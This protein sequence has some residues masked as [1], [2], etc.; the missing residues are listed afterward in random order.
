MHF[1]IPDL[2]ASSDDPQMVGIRRYVDLY[3][4]VCDHCRN[5]ND[6]KEESFKSREL[7]GTVFTTES[8]YDLRIE[9]RVRNGRV[10]VGFTLIEADHGYDMPALRLVRRI[11][12]P[13]TGFQLNLHKA[14]P[15]LRRFVGSLGLENPAKRY[16]F[17]DYAT[18]IVFGKA[19]QMMRYGFL[20]R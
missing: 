11:G 10:Q 17:T 13:W 18:N 20:D 14:S 2:S 1:G 16:V 3:C 9:L 7:A 5:A 4:A 12:E 8:G 6:L 15:E 19:C